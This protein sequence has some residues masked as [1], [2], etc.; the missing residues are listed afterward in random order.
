[1]T[2]PK[3]Q[4]FELTD[5]EYKSYKSVPKIIEK[6]FMQVGAIAGT[7]VGFFLAYNNFEFINMLAHLW[8]GLIIGVMIFALLNVILGNLIICQHKLHL[9][10]SAYEADLLSYKKTQ[11]EHW[12]SLSGKD[13]E[14]E[15]SNLFS[16][17]GYIVELTPS[18]GDQ[19][20][21]IVLRKEGIKIIVQCK[22]HA[23]PVGPAVVRDLYGTLI[24][25]KANSAILA[26][27]SG[28]T[29]GVHNFVKGK[30]IQLLLLND[31]ILMSEQINQS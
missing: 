18:S 24:A 26:S 20:I 14:R 5:S 22:A 9:K 30:R 17:Q 12:K 10:V 1:M 28:F 23:N 13:F 15:L 25:S 7:I 3:L 29:K 27:I 6:R 4:D 31:I 8:V 11:E 21:D 2:K 16:S 19:G